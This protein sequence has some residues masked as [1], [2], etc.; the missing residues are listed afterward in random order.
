[1]VAL[2]FSLCARSLWLLV[3]VCQPSLFA[4]SYIFAYSDMLVLTIRSGLI[5]VH[6]IRSRSENELYIIKF[7]NKKV[8]S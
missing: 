4:A 7:R 3:V 5:D 6:F 1:M 8:T 2:V